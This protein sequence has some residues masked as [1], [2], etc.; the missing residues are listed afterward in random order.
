MIVRELR[1]GDKH[2]VEELHKRFHNHFATPDFSKF[3]ASFV[4][5]NDDGEFILAGGI[6]RIAEAVLVTD[7]SRN[8]V[9]IGRA[10]KEA[11]LVSRYICEKA[12]INELVAFVND[13][14]YARHL[15]KHGF[16]KRSQALSMRLRHG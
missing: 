14:D 15:I 6:D 10:L 9:T 13:E 5:E 4:I 8:L 16:S 1:E 11:Q 12:G 3:L 7:A 2:H